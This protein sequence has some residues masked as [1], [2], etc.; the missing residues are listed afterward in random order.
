M[1][2][3]TFRS[4]AVV[5]TI[6]LSAAVLTVSAPPAKAWVSGT[7]WDPGN[8]I[9]D[10]QFFDGEAMSASQIQSFLNARVPTCNTEWSSGPSDPIVCLKDFR[11]TTI[12]R[13]A[14][15]YCPNAYVGGSNETAATIISKVARACNISP[16]VILVTLQKE[17]GLVTHT[18]PSA[19]RYDI[20][21]GY[22]CPDT[23]TGCIDEYY[24]FQNQVWRAARQFQRYRL[25]PTSYNYRAGVTNRIGYH[26]NAGC[27]TQSVYIQNSATAALYNYTPYVPN[28]A[29][30]AAIPGTGNS[31]SSYGNRNFFMYY[32]EWFGSPTTSKSFLRTLEDPTVYIV[33]G[34]NKYP[35]PDYATYLRMSK[36]GGL[37]YVSQAYLDA[38][39]T[40]QPVG[41]NFKSS[42][43]TIALLDGGSLYPY[44]TCQSMVDFGSSCATDQYVPL[45]D[46]QFAAFGQGAT[47]TNI[48]QTTTAGKYYVK[49]GAKSEILDSQSQTAANITGETVKLTEVALSDVDYAPPA[50]RDGVLIRNRD[51]G[52]YVLTN[53][54][55]GT[56]IS[57]STAASIG[58]STRSAGA[59]DKESMS[60]IPASAT[61]FDGVV[62]N[63]AGTTF[64][65]TPTTR[66]S[67]TGGGLVA[68]E[69]PLMTDE[70]LGL[71][72]D[73]GT[74]ASGQFIK[75]T[76]A[77]TIYVVTDGA[78][79]PFGSWPALVALTPSGTPTWTTV[80]PEL[81]AHLKLGS[82]VLTT[83][84]LVKSPSVADV[85]LIDG[86]SSKV[87][88]PS[89][90][91]AG[92]A[93]YTGYSVVSQATLDGYTRNAINMTYGYQC[94]A[95]KYI[96]AGGALHKI[97]VSQEPLYPIPF[98]AIDTYTC[99]RAKVGT[100][101]TRFIRTPNNGVIFLLESG[102]KRP[103]AS[104][105]RWLEI[106][107]GDTWTNVQP[108]LADLIPT[109]AAA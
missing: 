31:C 76:N 71:W 73:G 100:D 84:T 108:A 103:I 87:W 101:A 82:T 2:K 44:P 8:I 33:S 59:L 34:S 40:A 21:M 98:A 24:G 90:A 58:A 67:V 10:Q 69:S 38:Y 86:I 11:Q 75:A 68:Q 14:D 109:G 37:A 54:G 47:L 43:G 61:V 56:K 22:G 53:E 15:A 96:A 105:T 45:T 106:Y 32:W 64:V 25:L 48:V 74:I 49:D 30:L 93:G 85:Y 19:Y 57:A 13:S 16:K 20:A 51:D 77:N 63:G 70:M 50:I 89:F 3:A 91:I 36:L 42:N 27:G 81:I 1:T 62:R 97:A 6:A 52:S 26:P 23:G 95:T 9:S 60:L 12:D 66:V 94:G 72:A 92:E 28:A 102:T 17:Q 83:G 41:R 29:A 18:W 4:A 80:A 88:V 7:L 5:L 78:I 46:A 104:W 79:M 99:A 55:I 65:L 39:T 107:N 35:I